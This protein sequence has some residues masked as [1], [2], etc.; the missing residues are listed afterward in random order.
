VIEREALALAEPYRSVAYASLFED[1]SLKDIARDFERPHATLRSQH[2]RGL[3]LLRQRLDRA[4]GG[5]QAWILLLPFL[6]IPLRSRG[7]SVWAMRGVRWSAAALLVPAAFVAVW[8]LLRDSD[9]ANSVALV[10]D[11]G[12]AA[13]LGGPGVSAVPPAVPSGRA[14]VTPDA[15]AVETVAVEQSSR[16]EPGR[17]LAARVL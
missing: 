14:G 8:T 11:E 12:S 10:R 2:A 17:R 4:F 7:S 5:R 13:T 15:H 3:E 1:R 9:P 6:E 16:P